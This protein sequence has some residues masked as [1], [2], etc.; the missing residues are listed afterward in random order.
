MEGSTR[1]RAAFPENRVIELEGCVI[2]IDGRP[3][4]A[5]STWTNRVIHMDQLALIYI[6]LRID[7]KTIERRPR[8]R[9]PL[10]RPRPSPSKPQTQDQNHP[11]VAPQS[12]RTH[13]ASPQKTAAGASRPQNIGNCPSIIFAPAPPWPAPHPT[14]YHNRPA[15]LRCPWPMNSRAPKPACIRPSSR[16]P[17]LRRRSPSGRSKSP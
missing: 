2:E 11:F 3:K 9:Q 4:T 12:R 16:R 17:W 14:P 5:S 6:D 13:W 10:T 15:I 1:F 8:P 7:I